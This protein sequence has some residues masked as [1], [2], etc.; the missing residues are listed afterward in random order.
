MGDAVTAR[1][2]RIARSDRRR[3]V[4]AFAE[5][6]ESVDVL[7]S[8]TVP[9]VAPLLDE[10]GFEAA[11]GDLPTDDVF[12]FP[13]NLVGIPALSMPVG[14]VEDVPVGF[15]LMGPWGSDGRLVAVAKRLERIVGVLPPPPSAKLWPDA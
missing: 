5:A 12:T 4:K 14:L 8:P 2:E 11:Q 15:Q 1:T 13:A 10:A 3:L 9:R 7:V 6:F